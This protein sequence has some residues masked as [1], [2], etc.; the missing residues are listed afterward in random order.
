[1]ILEP[2]ILSVNVF[3]QYIQFADHQTL[4]LSICRKFSRAAWA[5]WEVV[6]D[7]IDWL[8]E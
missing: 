6:G 3:E 7:R 8:A 1:M 2:Q 5:A 4:R